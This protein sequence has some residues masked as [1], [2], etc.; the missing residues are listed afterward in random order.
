[1]RDHK[2][3]EEL[4]VQRFQLISPLLAEG[5]DAGK[6]KELKEQIAKTNGLSERTIRRYLAQFREEGFGGL[7]PQGRKT[8]RK[9]E[10]IPP[11]ILEQAIL[12]RK[13]VP[14]RSVAQIIQILE[15]EGLVEPGQIKRSTLQE[16]LTEKGYSSR[17]MRLYSQTGSA[18]RRFQK[19]HRN[20]LWQ[21][22][23][24]YGPYLPIGPNGV[25]KQVYLVAFIDDATRFVV[26]AAFYPTLDSR[27]IEDAFRQAI[28]K[29][30][31]PEAVYFDNGKQYRT[32]WMART[33]SK[34]GTRLTYTRPYAAE[35]KGKIE[36]FNRVIDSFI[37]EAVI[38]KPN[39]LDRLNELF[40]VW[41]IECYQN[42]RHSALEEKMSPETS[43][44]SD[45][46]SIRFIDPD[47]LSHAFLHCETRKVDKSGCISFMDQKYEV[48]LTFIGR[49]VDVVYDPANIEELTIEFEGY[50]PWKAKK[51]VIGERAGKRP[52]LPEHLQVQNVDSSRLLKAAERKNQERQ[53][54]QKPAVTFRSVWKEDDTRV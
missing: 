29:Y 35:S 8:S 22:D 33:C 16:K 43:F 53:I 28:Q 37:S 48:G 2:K 13:E 23:I 9:S 36:R 7:K 52:E 4:A 44:R 26:H 12:L 21:S 11:P 14:S 39:T 49:K 18:A 34:I 3:S 24:K 40:Q 50:T 42:K 20:Q 47:T 41:L 51:L 5:L 17:H 30:G 27:I 6:F 19:R 1:M 15:W 45:K 25:K 31:V 32:K 38:E 46:K 10:A 54:E